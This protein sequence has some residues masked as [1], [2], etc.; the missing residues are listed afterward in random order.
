ML[1]IT[2]LF[3]QF[4]MNNIFNWMQSFCLFV[5]VFFLCSGQFTIYKL[6]AYRYVITVNIKEIS[7]VY[8]K[9]VDIWYDYLK[10]IVLRRI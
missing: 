1:Q 8:V 4:E 9:M 2:H 6:Y 10:N 7:I 3:K 5:C